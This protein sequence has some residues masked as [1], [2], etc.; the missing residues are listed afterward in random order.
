MEKAKVYL[1]TSPMCPHCPPA[2]K[3]IQ[4]FKSTRDDFDLIELSTITHEGQ[5]KAEQF[6]VMS[7][8]TFIIRGPG[9]NGNIGLQG[10]QSTE[11][12]NKY[13]DVALGKRSLEEPKKEK[14]PF[15]IKIGR[16]HITF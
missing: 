12:M 4:N 8:P 2:K 9:Y 13:I 3:F 15:E 14:K 11:V 7:V 5:K 10:V 16:I 6:D 1:F